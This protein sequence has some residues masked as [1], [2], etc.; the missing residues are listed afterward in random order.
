MSSVVLSPL[1]ASFVV[2]IVPAARKANKRIVQALNRIGADSTSSQVK[3]LQHGHG[4]LNGPH[5]PQLLALPP[6]P[7]PSQSQDDPLMPIGPLV[8]ACGCV[9]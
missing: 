7:L 2:C 6:L 4:Q 8:S 1:N 3:T 5:T 9:G